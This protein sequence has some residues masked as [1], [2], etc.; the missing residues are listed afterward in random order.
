MSKLK[1]SKNK[2]KMN[3]IDSDKENINDDLL[4]KDKDIKPITP[5]QEA[6]AREM[7]EFLQSL[8]DMGMEDCEDEDLYDNDEDIAE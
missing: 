3:S 7:R 5:E 8:V 4:E 6:F 1:E 2:E